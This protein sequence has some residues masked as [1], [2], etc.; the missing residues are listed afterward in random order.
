MQNPKRNHSWK[1]G[2][3]EVGIYLKSRFWILSLCVLRYAFC[4]I[5]FGA[6]EIAELEEREFL[7]QGF[8]HLGDPHSGAPSHRFQIEVGIDVQVPHLDDTEARLSNQLDQCF[9][10][11]L[12]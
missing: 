10:L 12:L 5:F 11:L 9:Y 8:H 4:E 6:I 1:F 7:F 2:M 3:S